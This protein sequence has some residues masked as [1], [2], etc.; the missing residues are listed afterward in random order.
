MAKIKVGLLGSLNEHKFKKMASDRN[1][2]LLKGDDILINLNSEVNQYANYLEP[3]NIDVIVRRILSEN[4][5]YITLVLKSEHGEPLPMFR[6]GQ[7]VAATIMLDGKYYTRPFVLTS[8]PALSKDGEWRITLP[9]N[10]DD[11]AIDYFFSKILIG[12]KITMSAPFGDF[13]YN[14]IRDE[15]RVL[16]LTNSNGIIQ[17]YAMA[18]A[19]ANNVD[20]YYLTILYCE[21]RE[22]NLL[23]KDEFKDLTSI[24]DKIKIKYFLSMEEA[25]N[26]F[27]GIDQI[28]DELND[29]KASI[30]ISGDESLLKYLDKELEKINLPKKYIRYNNYLPAINAYKV[31][32]YRL[33]LYINDEKKELTCYNNKTIMQSIEDSGI[34]IPSKCRVGSCG[35]CRSELV[36][37]EVKVV[38]DKRNGVDKKYNYIHPCATYPMSDVEI[39]VR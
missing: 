3:K 34:Y 22:I 28:K 23:F 19:I 38:N 26:E 2:W 6:A 31:N 30:F 29:T 37:G 7:Y 10:K 9:K 32:K 1:D 16:F 18:Q 4:S 36:A 14:P 11:L 15:K 25:N 33:T 24:C 35:F 12:E 13:Y 39:V 21:K 5:D 27:I 8:N 20:N 17:A